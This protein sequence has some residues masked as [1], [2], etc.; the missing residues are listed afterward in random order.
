VKESRLGSCRSY[1][2]PSFWF[3]RRVLLGSPLNKPRYRI[4]MRVYGY[5]FPRMGLVGNSVN[6]ET[7]G[8]EAVARP[9]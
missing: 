4:P 1:R 7:T 5:G 9:S 6:R 3:P 8:L 2:K